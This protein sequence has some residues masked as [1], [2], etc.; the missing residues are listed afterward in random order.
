MA[1]LS[2][3]VNA[4]QHDW[5]CPTC[6]LAAR[7]RDGMIVAP[8]NPLIVAA[9]QAICAGG[10]H[11]RLLDGGWRRS[12]SGMPVYEFWNGAGGRILV[13]FDAPSAEDAWAH[14]ETLSALTLDAAMALLAGLTS[15]P[16]RQSA[17]A[18]RRA[19]VR[20]G[21]ATVLKAKGYRRFGS[22]RAAFAAAIDAE[23]VKLL[24]LRFDIVAYPGFDPQ[25]RRWRH[26]G[27][28]RSDVALLECVDEETDARLDAA[29]DRCAFARA[30]R[31]GAWADHWLY[32]AGAMWTAPISQEIIQLDHRENRSADALAKK[33]A[34]IL[35]L[36]LAAARDAAV[37]S[38]PT[39]VLLRRVGELRRTGAGASHSG[40]IADRLEEALLRLEE[41]GLLKSRACYERANDLRA[42]HRR[43]FEEWLDAEI[44][45]QR[46]RPSEGEEPRRSSGKRTR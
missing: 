8:N 26:E 6:R 14:I 21:A 36:N 23:C 5:Q 13:R 44:T 43:W 16:F 29:N 4:R 28:T 39:R 37:I 40:R 2:D 1:Y 17:C 24:R 38:M 18:P 25:S 3:T 30:W 33:I 15:D 9:V 34:L 11:A 12:K 41:R 46:A 45:F 27:I 10:A 22:E 20:L 31:L 19:P 35:T 32:S 42:F 7:A